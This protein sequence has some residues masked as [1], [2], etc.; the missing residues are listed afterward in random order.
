MGRG[1]QIRQTSIQMPE[2]R[3]PVVVA[4]ASEAQLH[5]S[6][7]NDPMRGSLNKQNLLE[8]SAPEGGRQQL[9]QPPHERAAVGAPYGVHVA[10]LKIATRQART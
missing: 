8:T 9:Q 1:L 7:D 5:Q 6:V 2:A 3:P 4:A 10:P